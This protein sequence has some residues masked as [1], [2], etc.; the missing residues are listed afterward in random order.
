MKQTP[1]HATDTIPCVSIVQ[2]Y[3]KVVLHY[4]LD[5]YTSIMVHFLPNCET[6]L[7][8]PLESLVHTVIPKKDRGKQLIY[9][10]QTTRDATDT[11]PSDTLG[12]T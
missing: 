9:V 10:L 3:L 5:I 6:Q 11:R 1:W 4:I 7:S 2:L 8:Q 12:R